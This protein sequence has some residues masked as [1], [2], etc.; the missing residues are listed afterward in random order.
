M[1]RLRVA[2]AESITL[3]IREHIVALNSVSLNTFDFRANSKYLWAKVRQKT[4]KTKVDSCALL[5]PSITALT[6]NFHYEAISTDS[7]YT[8]SQLNLTVSFSPPTQFSAHVV[9]FLLD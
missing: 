7:S 9:A 4:G 1:R 6:L 5:P 3:K 2:E 8:T